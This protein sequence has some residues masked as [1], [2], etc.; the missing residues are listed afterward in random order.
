M[1]PIPYQQVDEFLSW[2][3]ERHPVAGLEGRKEGNVKEVLVEFLRTKGRREVL[4]PSYALEIFQTCPMMYERDVLEQMK[5]FVSCGGCLHYIHERHQ[6]YGRRVALHPLLEGFHQFCDENQLS[7]AFTTAVHGLG[8]SWVGEGPEYLEHL[9]RE[10]IHRIGPD[11]LEAF[12]KYLEVADGGLIRDYEARRSEWREFSLRPQRPSKDWTEPLSM[13]ERLEQAAERLIGSL[14]LLLEGRFYK[15]VE[16]SPQYYRSLAGLGLVS[17]DAARGIE[18]LSWL[19]QKYPE[20]DLFGNIPSEEIVELVTAF[21][22]ERG[23]RDSDRFSQEVLKWLHGETDQIVLRRMTSMGVGLKGKASGAVSSPVAQPEVTP[24]NAVFLFHASSDSPAFI[25]RYW[26][27]LNYLTARHVNLY[28]SLEDAEQ[29]ISDPAAVKQLRNAMPQTSALPAL[30]MWK[31]SPSDAYTLPL[32]R[33]SHEDLFD[34][35]KIIVRDV[36]ENKER[37]DICLEAQR[38]IDRKLSTPLSAKVITV[39][40]GET[41]MKSDSASGGEESNRIGGNGG[42]A[43]HGQVS[44]SRFDDVSAALIVTGQEELANALKAA[45]AAVVLSRELSNEQKQEYAE[46]LSQIAEEAAKAKPNYTVLKSLCEGL[47]ALLGHVPDATR[48]VESVAEILRKRPRTVAETTEEIRVM[49]DRLEAKEKKRFRS[50]LIFIGVPVIAAL[51]LAFW[52]LWQ[53]QTLKT[54]TEEVQSAKQAVDQQKQ[55]VD[56]QEQ[57]LE[58]MRTELAEAGAASE[59]IRLGVIQYHAKN[60][61]GAVASYDKAIELD[62]MNPIVYDLKGYSQL[63]NGEVQKAVET[64]QRSIEIDPSYVWSHYDLALAYWASG[65]TTKAVEEVRTVLDIDPNLRNVIRTD[66]QFEKFRSSEEYRALMK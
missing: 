23:Y 11:F 10:Y 48:A 54:K 17:E 57:A 46:V 25:K 28:Y 7:E 64:L 32:E 65:D 52:V 38:F 37:A 41:P 51:G 24:C 49:L 2:L 18:F 27:D 47:K 9:F 6:E 39:E 16:E 61:E 40:E 31:G 43:V 1:I 50:A 3:S 62:P 60:Y 55:A 21:C 13:G 44:L 42:S 4:T 5:H 14:Y 20:L 33:L 12:E 29:R 58:S 56:Q 59:Q 26:M 45:R 35:M 66:G 63:R 8:T 30:L 22:E 36:V 19:R 15:D 53:A 34:L